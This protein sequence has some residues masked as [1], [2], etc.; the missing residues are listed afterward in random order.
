MYYIVN[1]Y[2]YLSYLLMTILALLGFTFLNIILPYIKFMLILQIWF[3]HNSLAQLKSFE[4]I[5][6]WNIRTLASFLHCPSRHSDS[7]LMPSHLPE[8]WK[9]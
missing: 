8:K 7:T 2:Q 4:L 1:D 9:S 6:R 5:M 3:T